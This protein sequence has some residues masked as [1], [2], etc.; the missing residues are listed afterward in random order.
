MENLTTYR[1]ETSSSALV[2]K[3]TTPVG[4]AYKDYWAARARDG[5]LRASIKLAAC[6]EMSGELENGLVVINELLKNKELPVDI[7]SEALLRKAVLEVDFPV[8]AWKTISG[9]SLEVEPE[10]RW[11]LHNQRG[12]ILSSQ[13]KYDSAIIEYTAAAFYGDLAGAPETVGHAH[14]NLAAIYR[15]IG[16]YAEAHESVDKAVALWKDYEYLPHALDSKAV[17]H[18]AE[19]QFSPARELAVEALRITTRHHRRWRAEFLGTLAKAEAGLA[20]FTESA[21]AIE[22]AFDIC[23][24]LEDESLR[25]EVLLAEKAALEMMYGAAYKSAIRLAL[26]LTGGNLRQA[27]KK[28]DIAHPVL[29]K[30]IRTHSIDRKPERLKSLTRAK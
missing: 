6:Y 17:I 8:S 25:L 4:E 23:D 15:K 9:A 30:A 19:K 21:R 24:Y 16:L 29:L 2:S 27:A 20:N 3:D 26:D 11:R 18:I 12:R 1:I 14:N 5:D 10:L 22:K 28:L 13:K 7:K